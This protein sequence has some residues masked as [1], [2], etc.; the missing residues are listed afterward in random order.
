[1]PLAINLRHSTAGAQRQSPA[2]SWWQ[3]GVAIFPG[4]T[5]TTINP[6]VL[7]LSG[8]I[9]APLGVGG[10]WNNCRALATAKTQTCCLQSRR[11]AAFPHGQRAGN[12]ILRWWC[13]QQGVVSILKQERKSPGAPGQAWR[14]DRDIGNQ[15]N[16]EL[17]INNGHES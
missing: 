8:G 13:V 17:C 3:R 11:I 2:L 10:A 7:R 5:Q 16:K 4:G 12:I 1:M 6:Y 14:L 9:D 15:K